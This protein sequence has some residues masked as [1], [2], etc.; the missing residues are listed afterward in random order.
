VLRVRD[1]QRAEA[2]DLVVREQAIVLVVGGRPL[3]RVQCLPVGVEDLALGLL[4][5]S[6]LLPPRDPIPAI[7]YRPD[8]NEI[9]VALDLS[10]EVVAELKSSLTLGSG[11]GSA[12]APNRE[13]DPF[14]C[15]RKID[16]AFR[17]TP[18]T[19]SRAMHELMTWSEVFRDT[20]AVHSA[21]IALA[22]DARNAECRMTNDESMTNDKCRMPNEAGGPREEGRGG[23]RRKEALRP[24]PSGPVPSAHSSSVIRHSSFLLAF[25]EDI[26]RHNAFDKVVGACRRQGIELFDKIGLVT[27]RLSLELVAK[28]VPA[29]LPVLASRGAPTDAAIR[30]AHQANLTLV[31]FARAGRMNIYTAPWRI[32]G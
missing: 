16:T 20:G 29:S 12:L 13:F 2:S 14:E 23:V 7:E 1:G 30:L 11:C 17:T 22:K 6:G 4:V 27:G 32:V 3:L 25:A 28:A 9:H 19:I 15:S 24:A 18:D 5:T 8:Q 26:G 31:G 10:D 21:G